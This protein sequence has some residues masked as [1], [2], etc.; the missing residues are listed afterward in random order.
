MQSYYRYACATN[1][2]QTCQVRAI[3]TLRYHIVATD[4][5]DQSIVC[6]SHMG[7]PRSR[8]HATCCR[9]SR[10]GLNFKL[11]SSFILP[12]LQVSAVLPISQL[13]PPS[14]ALGPQL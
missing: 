7:Q 4:H 10:V 9:L 1:I 8:L 3:Q 5:D 14:S 6:R 2:R 13:V 11:G 12:L